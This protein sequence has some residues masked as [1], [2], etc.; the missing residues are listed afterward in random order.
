MAPDHTTA[1]H[2]PPHLVCT[3]RLPPLKETAP[4]S[5]EHDRYPAFDAEATFRHRHHA[6][7]SGPERGPPV[8]TL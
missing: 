7:E 5:V 2:I 1:V 3:F 8:C 6:R 4:R